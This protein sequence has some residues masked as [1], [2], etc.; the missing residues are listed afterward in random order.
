MLLKNK[1]LLLI[2]L[3]VLILSGTFLSAN[4]FSNDKKHNTIGYYPLEDISGDGMREIFLP[5]DHPRFTG[6][7]VTAWNEGYLSGSVLEEERQ[8]RTL[9]GQTVPNGI[10]VVKPAAYYSNQ[11]IIWAKAYSYQFYQG[12]GE[13]NQF[14][15][16]HDGGFLLFVNCTPF[17][18]NN[19][20]YDVLDA[21]LKCNA[22]GVMT[23]QKQFSINGTFAKYAY[24][25]SGG[26]IFILSE[27]EGGYG[28]KDIVLHRLDSNLNIQSEAKLGGS[29]DEEIAN[30]AFS[31]NGI[32]VQGNT[33]SENMD[34]QKKGDFLAGFD[35]KGKRIWLKMAG[36]ETEELMNHKFLINYNDSFLIMGYRYLYCYGFDGQLRWKTAF[37][38]NG[39]VTTD[40]LF[41][42]SDNTICVRYSELSDVDGYHFLKLDENGKILKRSKDNNG[43][44]VSVKADVQGGFAL[45]TQ[46]NTEQARDGSFNTELVITKYDAAFKPI[47]RKTYRD[48]DVRLLSPTE[49][50][51]QY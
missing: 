28:G 26:D 36:E 12:H 50:L 44:L 39:K 49:T 6:T 9:N 21:V 38:D 46:R 48:G 24:E 32:V 7:A 18:A 11:E 33:K 3:T 25:T 13:V 5:A 20:T 45:Q 14:L 1:N 31:D 43:R 37:I 17:S 42:L 16:L 40:A 51:I 35:N 41:L 30:A 47:Y 34:F 10:S 8:P 19:R 4:F 2:L 22:E 23:A 15:P 29:Q 27:S